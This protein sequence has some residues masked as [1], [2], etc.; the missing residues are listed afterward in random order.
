MRT[1]GKSLLASGR[2]KSIRV[3]GARSSTPRSRCI[4]FATAPPRVNPSAPRSSPR[5]PSWKRGTWR[6]GQS[7]YVYI[8]VCNT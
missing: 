3:S 5:A 2:F 8:Y 4:T 6:W 1:C 7:S